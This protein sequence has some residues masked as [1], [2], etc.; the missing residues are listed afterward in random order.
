[1]VECNKIG[2]IWKTKTGTWQRCASAFSSDEASNSTAG[3]PGEPANMYQSLEFHILSAFF[4]S[5]LSICV[6]LFSFSSIFF[7][8]S[9]FVCQTIYRHTRSA[10][11]GI[12][13]NMLCVCGVWCRLL[14]DFIGIRISTIVV[15][16]ERLTMF[17]NTIHLPL[18]CQCL[19]T[20]IR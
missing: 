6:S 17:H 8:A 19:L 1:M 3:N 13:G 18:P 9:L 2:C 14:L 11:S 15:A 20:K 5:P 4:L 16:L 7:F 10:V 12:G